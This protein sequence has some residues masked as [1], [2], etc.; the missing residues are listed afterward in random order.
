[1]ASQLKKFMKNDYNASMS[2]SGKR[3]GRIDSD[4]DYDESSALQSES[5]SHTVTG[6]VDKKFEYLRQ[7]Y[8]AAGGGGLGDVDD[9]SDED[10]SDDE[11][12]NK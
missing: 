11:S 6:S 4:D 12:E 1:M 5:Q 3:R 8:L 9:T 7:K 10:D 2:A